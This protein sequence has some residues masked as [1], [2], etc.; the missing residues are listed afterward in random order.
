MKSGNLPKSFPASPADWVALIAAAPGADRA[1]TAEEK[2]A[3]RDAVVV[4]EGGLPAVR[5]ALAEKRARGQRG[6][7]NSVGNFR[8]PFRQSP[9][10]TCWFLRRI[11]R[12]SRNRAAPAGIVAG[13]IRNPGTGKSALAVRRQS[14][15]K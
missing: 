1:M 12:K 15:K 14:S 3:F 7:Q 9:D 13:D 5:S 10:K 8:S 11:C 6:V 2:A 4:R